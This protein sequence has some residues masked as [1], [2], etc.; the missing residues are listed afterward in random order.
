MNFL[1]ELERLIA[2]RS[3]HQKAIDQIDEELARARLALSGPDAKT[4][5]YRQTT[6][7]TRVRERVPSGGWEAMILRAL[8]EREPQT[9]ATLHDALPGSYSSVA[10]SCARLWKTGV[11]QRRKVTVG[12]HYAY[13]RSAD[14]F[15]GTNGQYRDE[16]PRTITATDPEAGVEPG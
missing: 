10:L 3:D 6:N 11:L 8:T 1:S 12:K 2:E 13:A 14:A 15:V 7:P 4:P 16:T 9:P 5:K